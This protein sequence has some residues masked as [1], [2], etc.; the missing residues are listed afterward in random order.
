MNDNFDFDKALEA[1]RSGKDL[2]GKDGAGQCHN[3]LA[4]V[5]HGT[6]ANLRLTA[7]MDKRSSTIIRELLIAVLR[8]G[9]PQYIRTDNEAIF[10]SR[11]FATALRLLGIH[12]QTIDLGCPWQN[13]RVERFFGTLKRKLDRLAVESFAELDGAL[14]QF[15]LWYNHVR[16]HQALDGRTP[17]EVWAG[18][19]VIPRCRTAEWF[20]AWD[21]LLQ[22]YYLRQ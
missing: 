1:L 2:T 9:K 7:L 13:G 20:E 14:G 19:T 17:A 21:G 8:Y 4:L 12:H 5:D 22:G 10:T 15:R 6:R 18:E 11:Y 3:I 16:P